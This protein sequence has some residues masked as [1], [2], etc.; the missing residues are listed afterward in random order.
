VSCATH[1]QLASGEVDTAHADACLVCRRELAAQQAMRV[2]VAVLPAPRL[3]ADRRRALAAEVMARADL[4]DDVREVS[5]RTRRVAIGGVVLG[6]VALAAA[7]LLALFVHDEGAASSPGMARGASAVVDPRA[8]AVART[9]TS[10]AATSNAATSNAATSN[11]ATASNTSTASTA[12]TAPIDVGPRVE[13]ARKPKVDGSRQVFGAT[14]DRHGQAI[15]RDLL[16]EQSPV[17]AFRAGW[18]ALRARRYDDAISA[19]DRATDPAVAEDAAFWAAIAA[20]RAGRSDDARKRLDAFL[21]EF[22]DS[23]RAESARRARESVR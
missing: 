22:P 10:N 8:D 13:P 23:P 17:V 16:V 7:A 6:G 1:D 19:F 3:D 5:S 21:A 9:A 2:Q 11:A 12:S 15:E 20:Q 4:H 14:T 18:E